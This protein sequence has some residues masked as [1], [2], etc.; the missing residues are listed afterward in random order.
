MSFIR[1]YFFTGL[2]VSAPIGAT[3]YITIFIV[4]FISGLVPDRFNP[5]NLLP[6]VIGYKIPGLEL[7]IAFLTFIF[8][9][10]I[11]S[12]L[13]GR[14]ILSYFDSLIS[15]I[16]FAGNVYKAIKQI[17]ET[18]SNADNAYQKVV[19]IQYPRKDVHA[20]GF[21]T[22]ETKGEVKSK[23]GIEMVNVFVPTT[24]NPTSGFLLFFP[25]DDIVELDM[26]V[27][28]AIKLVV[29]AG[30]VIPAEKK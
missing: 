13:F 25:K 18:F 11:F 20:I 26:S 28:D 8:L 24:P 4:N 23:T 30:M 12:T 27:E 3:I 19:L 1:R 7:I 10:I 15:R 9:G 2:L 22:G 14:S 17:T 5:N 16:P 29:S 6:E 21:M